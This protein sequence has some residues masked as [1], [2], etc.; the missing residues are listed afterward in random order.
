MKKQL[1]LAVKGALMGAANVIPG[2]SGGTVAVLTNVL[3]ELVLAIRSLDLEAARLLLS[4]RFRAF[5]GHI[6][7]GFLLPLGAGVLVSVFT[8][9]QVLK[10][11]FANHP[12][13]IWSFF[14]GLILVSVFSVLRKIRTVTVVCV[15]LFALGAVAA[16]SMAFLAPA[17][18]NASFAYLMLCGAVATCSMILPGLSGSYVLLLMGNYQL[19]MIEAVTDFRIG[20]LVPVAAGAALGLAAFARFLSWVF[21]RFYDQTIALLA[22]F[23][24]GSLSVLWPWKTELREVFQIGDRVKE[25]VVGYVYELPELCMETAVALTAMALGAALLLLLEK[26]AAGQRPHEAL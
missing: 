12:V 3:E 19:V 21:S 14:F 17:E 20:I 7:L 22:G 16:A 25:K 11:L 13:M 10:Y 18:E 4:G 9:A 15:A 2:V 26:C 23:I 1:V 24:F 5:A 6:H 8:I